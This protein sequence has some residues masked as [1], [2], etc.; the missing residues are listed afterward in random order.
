MMAVVTFESAQVLTLVH[1]LRA[2][3]ASRT[4]GPDPV[5]NRVADP[6]SIPNDGCGCQRRT[7][8]GMGCRHATGALAAQA[9]CP[10]RT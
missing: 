4:A 1:P 2:L 10:L 6:A 5:S 9:D 7:R 8:T 3:L